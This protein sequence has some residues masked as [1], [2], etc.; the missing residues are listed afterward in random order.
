[1]VMDQQY[2]LPTIGMNDDVQNYCTFY[3]EFMDGTCPGPDS[4]K[5]S[6]QMSHEI[7][8]NDENA[9][10]RLATRREIQLTLKGPTGATKKWVVLLYIPHDT[11]P[12][13]PCF[14]GLHFAGNHAIHPDPDIRK[15]TIVKG[16]EEF[17]CDRGGRARKWQVVKVLSRRFTLAAVYSGEVL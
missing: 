17:E 3:R 11:I 7:L 10:N 15:L 14:L 16:E 5:T 4:T 13:V 6:C 8:S 2:A 1:M 12:P 9:L